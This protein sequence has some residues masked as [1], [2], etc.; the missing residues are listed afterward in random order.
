MNDHEKY[1]FRHSPIITLGQLKKNIVP[2][3][4]VKFYQLRS[5]KNPIGNIVYDTK[6]GTTIGGPSERWSEQ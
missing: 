1:L 5:V 2:S 6:S 3:L 4:M